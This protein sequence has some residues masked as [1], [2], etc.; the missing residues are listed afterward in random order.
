MLA[1]VTDLMAGE[2]HWNFPFNASKG[3]DG[4]T[5]G[6]LLYDGGPGTYWID[7]IGGLQRIHEKVCS[8]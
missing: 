4:I 5:A 1:F 6:L 8:F 7:A 3:T 2:L